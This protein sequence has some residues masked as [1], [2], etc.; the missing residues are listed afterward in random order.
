[1]IALYSKPE[2]FSAGECDR[3]IAAITALPSKDAMLVGQTKDHSLRTAKLVWVDDVDRLGW[4]MDRLIEIVRKSNIE[5][6]DFDLREF[7]ESPQVASYN[8]ADSGHFAWHSDIGDGPVASKRK[9]TLVLQLSL[10]S[11]YEG[12]DLEIMPS[13]QVLSASRAQGCVSIFP[14]FALHQ[15]VPVQLGIRHSLTLWAHGPAF[16]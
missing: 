8:A 14:S 11:S 9:L 5:Q 12:G 13:A 4:V 3:I 16:R 2:A 10:P 15:V 1:M 7:A 6:F